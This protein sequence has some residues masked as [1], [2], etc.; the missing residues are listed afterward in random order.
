MK[1]LIITNHFYPENFR[2]NDLASGMIERGHKV[3]V[4][5]SIPNYPQ[6]KFF[7]GYGFFK[8]RKET[9]NQVEIT[10]VPVIPRGGGGW[11]SD[12]T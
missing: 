10:R 2:I 6:G 7:P 9:I 12:V 8:K 3:S 5:T 11:C 4:M 1:I